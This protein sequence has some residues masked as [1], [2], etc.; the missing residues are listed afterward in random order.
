MT[1]KSAKLRGLYG[2]TDERLLPHTHALLSSAEAALRGGLSILQYR[3]KSLT[4]AEQTRQAMA[5]RRLCAEH[6]AL[7]IINDDV[8]LANAVAADGVHIGRDDDAIERARDRL[9]D[10][11]IIG[12]S[13]YNQLELA[14]QAQQQGADYVAF[15]RF[16]ASQTK[17]DAVQANTELLSQAKTELDIPLCAIGGITTD[18]AAELIARGADMIAVIH[19]LFA[20][21]DVEQQSQRFQRLFGSH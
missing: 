17:P 13:C 4:R 5:L 14:H 1:N 15:G 16:F 10:A 21:T 9:G 8:E 20:Q 18:N 6:D 19:D 3:A 7:F 11:A 2:I 12:V